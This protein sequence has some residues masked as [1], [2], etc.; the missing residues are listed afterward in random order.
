MRVRINGEEK[1]IP[2]GLSIQKMLDICGQT[3]EGLVV[4]RNGKIIDR[5]QFDSLPVQEGDVFEL[6]RIVGGG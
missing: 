5:Q 4:E 3:P 2:D 1:T 6:I